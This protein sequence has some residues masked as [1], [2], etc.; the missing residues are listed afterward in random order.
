M[1]TTTVRNAKI[2][3]AEN[4]ISDTSGLVTTVVFN[5]KITEVEIK[6]PEVSG[7]VKKMNYNAKIS[8]RKNIFLLL[9]IIN[10]Q[11]K[12]FMQR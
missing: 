10:S 4:K 3:E 12:Y 2:H 8:D 1:T 6:I 7:L 9:I 11:V 5:T